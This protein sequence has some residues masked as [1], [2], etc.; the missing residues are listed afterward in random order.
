ML[1]WGSGAW[2]SGPALIP[3]WDP[4]RVPALPWLVSS[5]V[6]WGELDEMISREALT[7]GLY[8][9]V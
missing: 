3:S 5:S 4:G 1:V 9:S 7:L 2:R 6:K 8:D